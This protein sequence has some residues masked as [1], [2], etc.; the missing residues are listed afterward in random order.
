MKNISLFVVFTLFAAIQLNDPDPML[1]VAIYGVV[2]IVALLAHFAPQLPLNTPIL[3]YQI[4]LSIYAL[5]YVPSLIEY[6][7]QPD[8]IELVGQMKAESPWIEG[9]RELLGLLIA[10]V[11]LH[12]M[13]TSKSETAQA[14]IEST[15]D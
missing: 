4:V 3:V 5:F 9:T 11:A 15:D 1:W 13:K 7:A 10:V 8:K 6:V 12:F 14:P 2:A